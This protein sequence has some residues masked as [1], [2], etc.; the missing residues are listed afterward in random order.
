MHDGREGIVRR[1][2]HIDVVIGVNGFFTAHFA[3]ENFDGA[4]GNNLVRVHVGLR[5]RP[6]LPD[7]QRKL[8]GQRAVD[9][10][11]GGLNNRLTQFGV[12]D[13]ELHVGLRRRFFLD[14]EGADE[15]A[16]HTFVTDAEILDRALCLRA[17]VA[18]AGDADFTEGIG[19][20]TGGGRGGGHRFCIG[21]HG[22]HRSLLRSITV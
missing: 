19:F 16:R 13:G 3:A 7:D 15:G 8:T 14:A 20:D 11:I 1:L 18:V 12:K 9:N 10:I 5:A 22:C 17:P 6:G 21:G 2:A 4:V